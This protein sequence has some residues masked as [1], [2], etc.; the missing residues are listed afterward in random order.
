MFRQF[1]IINS[2]TLESS[3]F[4]AWNSKNVYLMSQKRKA[5][6][7]GEQLK[8]SDLT[9]V[10]ADFCSTLTTMIHS[11]ILKKKFTVDT[12][13]HHIYQMSNKVLK[14]QL[15]VQVKDSSQI[16]TIAN[17]A[18]SATLPRTAGDDEFSQFGKTQNESNL[19]KARRAKN[20]IN[21][22]PTSMPGKQP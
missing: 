17:G 3:F 16:Q 20:L 8:P 6:E 10:G 4:A 21:A 1:G 2:Y 18:A 7:E 14:K 9:Q 15:S 19:G 13:L 22:N 5:M 11:K 12:S